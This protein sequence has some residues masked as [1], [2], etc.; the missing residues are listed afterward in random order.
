MKI[1]KF[2]SNKAFLIIVIACVLLFIIYQ[3]WQEHNNI[4]TNRND[5]Y[6]ELNKEVSGV[7]TKAFFDENPNHKGFEIQFTNGTKYRPAYLKKWQPITL[8]EGDSIY[9]KSG[10]FKVTIF[11]KLYDNPIITVEDTVNCDKL[12]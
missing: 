10:T 5:C 11:R 4:I 7:V 12:K 6:T 3:K 8:S 2:S 9:K 1:D